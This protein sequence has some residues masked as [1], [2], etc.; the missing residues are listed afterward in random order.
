MGK[1][2]FATI[3][4]D[5]LVQVMAL[6]AA[7]IFA[8]VIALWLSKSQFGISL[9]VEPILL[10]IG[11]FVAVN[12]VRML[13]TNNI[14]QWELF[15]ELCAD[16]AALTAILFFSGGVSNPFVSFYLVFITAGAML[17]VGPLS[18]SLAALILLAYTFLI[19]NFQPMIHRHDSSSS[20]DL[21][22][23]GSW[24]T[25]ALSTLI[26]ATLLVKMV[27]NIKERERRLA[28]AREAQLRDERIVALGVF[29]AG[30]AHEL[31]TPLATI[32]TIA[33]ELERRS[34]GLPENQDMLRTLRAQVEVCKKHLTDLTHNSGVDR[35]EACSLQPAHEFLSS[36]LTDWQ[37][38][39]P[40][41][42][43]AYS[44]PAKQDAPN[45]IAEPTLEQA[46]ISVL[47]NAA[48][49]S[50]EKIAVNAQWSEDSLKIDIFD[51]G[52]GMSNHDLQ[53][54]GLVTFSNKAAR[55]GLGIGLYLARAAL[56]RFGGSLTLANRVDGGVK[57]TLL[58]PTSR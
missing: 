4:E 44:S 52:P 50:P 3:S 36:A 23:V 33:K 45:I 18:W 43:I 22:T 32:A 31:G 58:I 20:L 21:H 39:R 10:G 28:L 9:P 40:E 1:E 12:V 15:A 57:V 30:T 37:A 27:A 54:A 55:Q 29:A 11:L 49:A 34:G 38:M 42:K 47:N 48:D 7:L 51:T 17:L 13:R 25:F 46:L 14:S 24:V 19:F 56:E 6:R 5:N 41:A 26:V 16:I 8:L 53:R 35:S 2:P